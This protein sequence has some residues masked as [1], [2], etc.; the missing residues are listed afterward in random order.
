[1]QIR[2]ITRQISLIPDWPTIRCTRKSSTSKYRVFIYF[3][4]YYKQLSILVLGKKKMNVK[5][6]RILALVLFAL[7][8]FAFLTNTFF[9]LIILLES[10]C[11]LHYLIVSFILS[12][13]LS[14]LLNYM[15]QFFQAEWSTQN[16]R[17]VLNKSVHKIMI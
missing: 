14:I 15:L 11:K 3:I 12:L 13:S 9:K 7:N 16:S 1:M 4:T 5:Y 17:Q 2:L 8:L 6:C 10:L